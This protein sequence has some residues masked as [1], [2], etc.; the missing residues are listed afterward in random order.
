MSDSEMLVIPALYEFSGYKCFQYDDEQQVSTSLRSYFQKLMSDDRFITQT[1]LLCDRV[2]GAP[3]VENVVWKHTG[4]R[5][6]RN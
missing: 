4:G 2:W 5:I 3:E 1:Y 6:N